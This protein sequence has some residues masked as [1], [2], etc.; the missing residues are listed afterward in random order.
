LQGNI[1]VDLTST[2]HLSS[3]GAVLEFIF[4]FLLADLPFFWLLIFQQ[5]F[6]VNSSLQIRLGFL[7][8]SMPAVTLL[9]PVNARPV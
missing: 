1:P 2:E 4:R 6:C 3:S 5:R 8:L 9:W 7:A